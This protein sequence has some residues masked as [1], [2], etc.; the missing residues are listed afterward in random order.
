MRLSPDAGRDGLLL[1]LMATMLALAVFA[2]LF[3]TGLLG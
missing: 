2:L 1:L 3:A